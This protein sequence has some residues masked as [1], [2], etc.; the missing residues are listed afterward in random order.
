MYSENRYL[1]LL[2][3]SNFSV[4]VRRYLLKFTSYNTLAHL[5][6]TNLLATFYSLYYTRYLFFVPTIASYL[7]HKL[8]VVE[9]L[10]IHSLLVGKITL[11]KDTCTYSKDNSLLLIKFTRSIKSYLFLAAKITRVLV[12]KKKLRTEDKMS[13][14]TF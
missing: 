9:I 7:L 11:L 5:W 10:K 6:Q 2:W 14:W 12:S 1:V 8:L 3:K 4:T 13:G